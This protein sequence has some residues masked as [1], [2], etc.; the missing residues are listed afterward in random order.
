MELALGTV[1]FGLDY[2][3]SNQ[4]GQVNHSTIEL[5]LSSAHSSGIETLD[6]ASAYGNSEQALGRIAASQAFQII[7]KVPKLAPKATSLLP[8]VEQSLANLKRDKLDAVMFHHA[9]DLIIHQHCDVL[10]KELEA[11]KKQ[12][13]IKR[14]GVSL[15]HPE[16]WHQ[17][18]NNFKLDLLQVPVNALDQR[19]VSE[20]LI[21][22]YHAYGVKLHC[23]SAFLQG[24]LLMTSSK[25]PSYFQP[26][27]IELNTFD[28]IAS[29]LNCSHLALCLACLH[30]FA[31]QTK[32]LS[33]GDDNLL[34]S[35]VVGCCSVEQLDEIIEANKLATS[36]L[37]KLSDSQLTK[38]A[39]TRQA[40]I[41]P[42]LWQVVK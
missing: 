5:I 11:L 15:Y 10:Y 34:E 42:S 12:G 39:S 22:D 31:Q 26:F 16:Q 37:P 20:K 23:R 27:A 30:Y 33:D 19:F 24:L 3:V 1:Q 35:I 29:A 7:T 9:D 13:V 6:T 17:L 36:L 14:I 21:N 32:A 4:T 2:G 40:L 28:Q 25:R 38:L 41:N 18:K 8:F